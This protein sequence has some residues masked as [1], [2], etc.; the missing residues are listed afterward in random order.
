MSSS[1][2]LC[3]HCSGYNPEFQA[4]GCDRSFP[5]IVLVCPRLIASSPVSAA[6]KVDFVINAV[7]VAIQLI[8]FTLL[9]ARKETPKS[10]RPL[11][12]LSVPLFVVLAIRA[13]DPSGV[14]S[15]EGT[16]L[17]TTLL[18]NFM[19]FS[20]I[21][22]S[23][24]YLLIQTNALLLLK[25]GHSAF[26]QTWMMRFRLLALSYSILAHL[27]VL[28]LDIYQIS[29]FS[30]Q[31]EP[32]WVLITISFIFCSTC[33]LFLAG[34]ITVFHLLWTT[35]KSL[36]KQVH[37]PIALITSAT[38]SEHRDHEHMIPPA[39]LSSPGHESYD[40]GKLTGYASTLDIPS[41]Q[42]QHHHQQ[43]QQQHQPISIVRHSQSNTPS[44]MKFN[45]LPHLLPTSS[46]LSPQQ[47]HEYDR[48]ILFAK[49]MSL[50]K[51]LDYVFRVNVLASLLYMTAVAFSASLSIR[52]LIDSNTSVTST[53]FDPENYVFKQHVLHYIQLI[54]ISTLLF[55]LWFRFDSAQRTVIHPTRFSVKSE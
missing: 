47:Q 3:L 16:G 38:A 43:Q 44:L 32:S 4:N 35:S 28:G 5:L 20:L 48:E 10:Q 18:H 21:E 42:R 46:M 22:V 30:S 7:V 11:I 6:Y 53:H 49:F 50:R 40:G 34:N 17:P 14:F 55:V 26:T 12:A 33:L 36:L 54:G 37:M 25:Y 29:Q 1:H 2:Q 8:A 39:L 19:T 23:F 31:H 27:A 52:R 15:L 13:V 24:A 41:E 9:F 51:S 45:P